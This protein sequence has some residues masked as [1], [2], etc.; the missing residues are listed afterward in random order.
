[1][2]VGAMKRNGIWTG[3]CYL[4]ATL[5]IGEGM[6]C[7]CAAE[8]GQ[9]ALDWND[10]TEPDLQHYNVYRKSSPTG[11]YSKI[12]AAPVTQSSYVDAGL[13]GGTYYYVVTA[14]D[15]AGNESPQSNEVSIAIDASGPA[16]SSITASP[17][18]AKVG[19][20]ISITFTVSETLTANPSVTVNGHA[21][22]FQSKSG[23]NYTYSYTVATS[24]ADGPATILISGTD[25]LGN[26]GSGSSV[27]A[28]NVDKQAPA[29]SV[30]GPAGVTQTTALAVAWTSSDVPVN[31]YASGIQS[32]KVYWNRNGGAYSLLGTYPAG[33]NGVVFDA[34]AHG[35]DGAYGFYSAA[36]DNAGNAEAAPGA[37]DVITT[38]DTTPPTFSS[39]A[40]DP[41][42]AAQGG[43]V[44]ITFT[45]SE[46]L[47]ANP[48]VTV[49]SHAANYQS[50]SGNAYTYSYTVQASDAD[51][52]AT[53][54][55]NGADPAGLAGSLSNTT[56]LRVDNTGAPAFS[57][58]A[59]VPAQAKA[60]AAVTLT[61]TASEALTANPTVTV[62]GR[63]ATYQSKSGNAYTYAY[64]IQ[65]ADAEGPA[66]IHISGSD[67]MGL[68]GVADNTTALTVDKTAP[69]FSA[70]A[71]TPPKSPVGAAV[72]VT[73]TASETLAAQ[74]VVTVN[75]RPAS[76]QSVTDRNFTYSY[77]I[78]AQDPEG[79]ATIAIS[80]SDPAGN[81]GAASNT[82]ALD[83]DKPP[84]APTGLTV[85][86]QIP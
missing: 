70:V 8:T 28:L 49:N 6:R 66:T 84:A 23:S 52:A 24:D 73:F 55:L 63:A 18:V 77:T 7:A 4:I 36:T 74:P 43:S 22:A 41:S 30:S 61:F 59:A 20:S 48:T 79:D 10:N 75:G 37:A 40:A 65:T 57:A 78:V 56:A 1:M 25:T 86:Q 19:A 80:G 50:K 11:T 32:V 54:Q 69:A 26:A 3:F 5:L 14:V 16:F 2:G 29:S 9:A 17:S 35:G 83:V 82:T 44:S 68:T 51:G 42:V 12:N 53:I 34:S 33:T 64:A 47:A 85:I 38:V 13:A 27:T 72:A 60:A 81:N 62:N 76:F 39:V 15:T 71:A 46:T 45:A 21:A 58:I 31:A 67:S